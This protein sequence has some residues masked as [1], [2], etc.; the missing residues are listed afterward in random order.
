M[1]KAMRKYRLNAKGRVDWVF[2][3]PV[4]ASLGGQRGFRDNMEGS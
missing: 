1:K 4:W 2:F 3:E